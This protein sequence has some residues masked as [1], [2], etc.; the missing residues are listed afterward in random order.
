MSEARRW[1]LER[2]KQAVDAG[3]SP[4]IVDR[5]NSRCVESQ[6][7]ARYAV[8]RGYK[9]ELKEPE[10]ECWQQIRALLQNKHANK[11]ILFEWADRLQKMSRSTHRVP[12]STIR[13][14]M[15]KW[16]YDL[17][18]EDILNYRPPKEQKNSRGR[19]TL[20]RIAEP[21]TTPST[22]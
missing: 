20:M 5:G 6:R 7:Y 12:A 1:N 11:E 15:G 17:T 8:D 19:D 10:S 18:I 22:R 13:R 4:I 3:R 21:M 2:F 16:K 9:V 14:W